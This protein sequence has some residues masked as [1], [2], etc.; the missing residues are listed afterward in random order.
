MSFI[1]CKNVRSIVGVAGALF[2]LGIVLQFPRVLIGSEF[3]SLSVL[4]SGA[5]LLS[6]L[7]SPLLMISTAL[8]ALFPGVSRQLRLCEH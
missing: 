4:L 1:N 6:M 3:P 8:L 5:G 7:V 2:A